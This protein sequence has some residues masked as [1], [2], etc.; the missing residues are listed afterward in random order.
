MRKRFNFN[1]FSF[2][3]KL[4]YNCLQL[5]FQQRRDPKTTSRKCYA[6]H[7]DPQQRNRR[8]NVYETSKK[9]MLLSKYSS[10][11][12][13]PF[14]PCIV[15]IIPPFAL[16]RITLFCV[17]LPTGGLRIS[18]QCIKSWQ[19]EKICLMAI[20]IYLESCYFLSRFFEP[21]LEL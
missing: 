2:V 15:H 7:C 18:P 14:L 5:C 10:D 17:T 1:I 6:K 21:D 12:N 13:N 20:S 19:G 9:V 3:S 11:R 8:N 4:N 16:L